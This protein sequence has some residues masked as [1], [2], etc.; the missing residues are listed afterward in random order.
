[1]C[2]LDERILERLAEKGWSTPKSMSTRLRFNA[3]QRRIQ[4][5]CQMLSQAGLISPLYQDADLY[6]I[7]SAGSEYLDGQLDVRHLPTP[8]IRAL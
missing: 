8:S 4:E 3:S 1:M 7:T 6:E 5:R 2:T